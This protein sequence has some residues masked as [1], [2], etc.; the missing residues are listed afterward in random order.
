MWRMLGHFGDFS[1]SEVRNC[2]PSKQLLAESE[3]FED[4]VLSG[5]EN[6]DSPS[7]EMSERRDCGQ[8]HDQNLIEIRR[9]KLVCKPF[10]PRVQ[11][12][13][14]E[15]QALH[16]RQRNHLNQPQ[17]F[18][19]LRLRFDGSGKPTSETTTRI[20]KALLKLRRG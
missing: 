15:G 13:F 20:A 9:I 2:T 10:I 3:I 16:V 12:S 8:N 19:V 17:G 11:R 5:T 4:E 7:Q 1:K 18:L 6:T 14:D